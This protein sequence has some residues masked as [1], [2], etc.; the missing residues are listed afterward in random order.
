MTQSDH[1]RQRSPPHKWSAETRSMRTLRCTALHYL[2]QW[3]RSVVKSEGVR[4][5]RVKL[6]NKKADR[7]SFSF[8]APKTGYL[9][10]F[11]FFRFRPKMNFL[12]CFIF[13]FHSKNVICIGRKCYVRNWTITKFCHTG[14]GD[15][16]FRPKMEFHF[17]RHFLRPKM[18]N[19]SSDGLYIKLFQITP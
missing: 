13:R 17:R 18:K 15:F 12:L 19:A 10:I 2:T 9:V 5:T 1:D 7:N 16:R 8:S 3:R 6:S 11:G 4:V 14:T